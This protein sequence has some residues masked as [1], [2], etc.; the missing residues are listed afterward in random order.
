[1][2][3]DLSSVSRRKRSKKVSKRSMM[4]K[5]VMPMLSQTNGE[6]LAD[7]IESG[8]SGKVKAVMDR[9]SKQLAEKVRLENE[10]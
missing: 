9:I 2:K 8:N 7:A 5:M 3:I 1:M 4:L 6:Q 10:K